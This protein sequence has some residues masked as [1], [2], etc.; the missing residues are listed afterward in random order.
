MKRAFFGSPAARMRP[1]R[2]DFEEHEFDGVFIYMKGGWRRSCLPRWGLPPQHRTS[3][4]GDAEHKGKEGHGELSP[5][6]W[7]L[8]GQRWSRWANLQRLCRLL[9]CV[10]AG[11]AHM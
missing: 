4:S 8:L 2:D 10:I 7:D 3:T 5:L 1:G 9:R 6:G 11:I